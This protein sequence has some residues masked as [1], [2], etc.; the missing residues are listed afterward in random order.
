MAEIF[1]AHLRPRWNDMEKDEDNAVPAICAT[2]TSLMG[3]RIQI[4]Q[5][6]DRKFGQA[7]RSFVGRQVKTQFVYPRCDRPGHCFPRNECAPLYTG[8]GKYQHAA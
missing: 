4:S 1:L 5:P 3:A 6:E 2:V 8:I 7:S